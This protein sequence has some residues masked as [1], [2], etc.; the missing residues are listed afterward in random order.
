[1]VGVPHPPPPNEL[2]LSKLTTQT[3]EQTHVCSWPKVYQVQHFFFFFFFTAAKLR[4]FWVI[5]PRH[6]ETIS[7]KKLYLAVV[8]YV[9]ISKNLTS[10]KSCLPLLSSL[11]N[12]I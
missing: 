10:L 4:R 9:L 11:L 8:A 12:L 7:A 6:S 1:M 3:D 5:E 2:I